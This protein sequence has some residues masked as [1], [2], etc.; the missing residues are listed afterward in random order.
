MLPL[1]NRVVTVDVLAGKTDLRILI[2]F[3]LLF[4]ALHSE[5]SFPLI[6]LI[7]V[8]KKKEKTNCKEESLRNWKKIFALFLL[9]VFWGFF[10][11]LLCFLVCNC[12]LFTA[13][14]RR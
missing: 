1:C 14:H 11:G 13:E 9:L 10:F 8:G 6:L 5:L 12:R 3:I 4:I 2:F 7:L